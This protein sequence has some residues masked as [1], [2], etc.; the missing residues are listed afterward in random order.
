MKIIF[1]LF[2][3]ILLSLYSCKTVSDIDKSEEFAGKNPENETILEKQEENKISFLFLGDV[4]AHKVNYNMKDYNKIWKDV[5]PIIQKADFSFANI[6]TPIDDSLEYSTYPTFNIKKEYAEAIF[7]SGLNIFSLANNHTNDQG[8]NGIK[9]TKKYTDEI[10]KTSENVYFSGINDIKNQP[11]SYKKIIY[12]NWNIIFC[13]VTEIL[14]QNIGKSYINFVDYTKSGRE[15]FINRIKEIKNSENCDLFI[16]SIHTN[17]PEY[18]LKVKEERKKYYYSLLDSGVDVIWAN[19]PHIIREREIIVDSVSEKKKKLIMY[20]NGN[21]ISGQ[22]WK[23]QFSKPETERDNTGDG[24]MF[25]AEFSKNPKTNEISI[26]KTE[27][28]YIT[29]YINTAWNFVIKNLNDEFINYLEENDRQEWKY[30]I[31]KRKEITE[32]TKETLIWQ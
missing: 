19:H 12:K 9:N 11:I 5:K 16:L 24:L 22:R 10:E 30:Y 31:Q 26:T 21:T 28:Y 1:K 23:P 4:M 29:T 14:N 20:G 27:P 13:A 18:A 2:L 15:N 17:E 6:E 7:D 8:I 25:Y 32:K 3:A